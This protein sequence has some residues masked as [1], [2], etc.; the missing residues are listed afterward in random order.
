MD[1]KKLIKDLKAMQKLGATEVW[2]S[3]DEEGNDITQ[4]AVIDG[5]SPE[6]YEES[7][8]I[9]VIYPVKEMWK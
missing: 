2:F 4:S 5:Y 9:I 6:I 8:G 7:N 1:I 3:N